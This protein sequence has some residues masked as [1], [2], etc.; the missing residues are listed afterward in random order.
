MLVER[1]VAHF[2]LFGRSLTPPI[3]DAPPAVV[4]KLNRGW[5]AWPPPRMA[6]TWRKAGKNQP[7]LR[8][9]PRWPTSRAEQ[10][11]RDQ[12]ERRSSAY[13]PRATG[14]SRCAHSSSRGRAASR[15]AWAGA[16]RGERGRARRVRGGRRGARPE[17]VAADGGGADRGA[18]PDRECPAGDHG[19]CDRDLA[20]LGHRPRRQGRF[21]R[22]PPPRRI[23]GAVRRRRVRSRHH[24]AAAEAARPGDAGGG[25]GG[26]G[27]DGGPA[28]RRSRHG[29]GGRRRGGA[30]RGLHRRQR[31]RS[32]RRS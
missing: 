5:K 2:L 30:G 22:R 28:R 15:S 4:S 19:Q 25:A 26:R 6:G 14:G 12:C 29:A 32:R 23:F 1:H 7:R 8:F 17:A 31:Q 27:G 18:D 9:A 11:A 10:E 3:A 16:G 20:R 24:G 13:Q 21:R